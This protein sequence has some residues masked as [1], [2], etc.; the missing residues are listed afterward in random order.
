MEVVRGGLQR[1]LVV[2]R[3]TSVFN[4]PI[5]VNIYVGCENKKY[6][7]S[8]TTEPITTLVDVEST[9][10]GGTNNTDVTGADDKPPTTEVAE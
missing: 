10:G 9:T 7:K 6:T 2:L 4:Y 5:S 1:N 3:L 8:A